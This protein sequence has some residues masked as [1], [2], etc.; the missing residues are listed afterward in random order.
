MI[1]FYFLVVN[2]YIAVVLDNYSAAVEEVSEGLMDDDLDMFHE[3]WAQ[4]DPERTDYIHHD[5]ISD[6]LDLLEP[7]FQIRKPNKYKIIVMDIPI[8]KGMEC[9]VCRFGRSKR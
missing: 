2:M 9:V 7:P 1:T 3:M 6:F 4:S 5:Q 8:C